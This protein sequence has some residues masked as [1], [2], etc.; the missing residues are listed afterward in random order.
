MSMLP[1][2]TLAQLEELQRQRFKTARATI[3][4]RARR[5]LEISNFLRDCLKDDGLHRLIDELNTSLVLYETEGKTYSLGH[6][7][8][9]SQK[10]PG[11]KI[12]SYGLWREESFV[13]TTSHDMRR[14]NRDYD[15][16]AQEI[17][18]LGGD[19]PSVR[20]RF[21][22]SLASLVEQLGTRYSSI[23]EEAD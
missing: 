22:K 9:L 19:Y 18:D 1:E 7:P 15:T 3:L 4:S 23:V 2:E 6:D 10:A 13:G 14:Q 5:S 16:A 21:E 8:L 11:K 20:A 12:Q 17:L